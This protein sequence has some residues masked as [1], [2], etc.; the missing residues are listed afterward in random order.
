MCR[1]R[2]GARSA[3]ARGATLWPAGPCRRGLHRVREAS[4]A[5]QPWWGV[6]TPGG[7]GMFGGLVAEGQG[8]S[9]RV[10][11]GGGGG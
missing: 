4:T 5:W 10:K 9:R 11:E 8:S 7:G 6:G 3:S 2:L 1:L